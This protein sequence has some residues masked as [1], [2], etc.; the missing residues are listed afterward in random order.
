MGR[1]FFGRPRRII[2]IEGMLLLLAPGAYSSY[3]V[4]EVFGG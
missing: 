2:Q 1:G 3:L 4:V